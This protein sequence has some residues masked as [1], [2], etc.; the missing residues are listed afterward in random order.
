MKSKQY[1]AIIFDMD[2]TIIDTE[3]IW[4]R[5][6]KELL[7]KRSINI[8]DT[9]SDDLQSELKGASLET[10]CFIIKQLFGLNEDIYILMKEKAER[11]NAL[12]RQ[13]VRFMKGFPDF[14]KSV[15]AKS[16]RT[17]LATNAQKDTVTITNQVLNLEQYFGIHIY[18]I[19]AVNNKGKPDP[20]IYLH[21]A[22]Q[23]EI[24]PEQCIAIEDS[25]HGLQAA[26]DA[27]MFCIGFNS[28]GKPDQLKLAHIIVDTYEQIILDHFHI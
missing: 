14:H 11:A 4:K 23:L 19:A 22:K 12:Y 28:S 24:N 10:S 7:A 20:A 6:I 1:K 17:G 5:A 2:G 15:V 21:T 3:H 16:L 13:E 9:Q 26:K 25:S 8:N 27:G 18:S